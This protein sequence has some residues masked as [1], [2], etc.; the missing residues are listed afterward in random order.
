M[1]HVR[2][3]S[4]P[5]TPYSADSIPRHSTRWCKLPLTDGRVFVADVGALHALSFQHRNFDERSLVGL[6]LFGAL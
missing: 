6:N 4:L 5:L 3:S 1:L 2:P